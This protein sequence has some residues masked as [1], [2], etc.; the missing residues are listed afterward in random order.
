MGSYVVTDRGAVTPYLFTGNGGQ[1]MKYFRFK[2]RLYAPQQRWYNSEQPVVVA[3]RA[4]ACSYDFLLVDRPFDSRRLTVSG[5]T[6]AENGSAA[7]MAIDARRFRCDRPRN[8]PPPPS[9]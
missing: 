8:H 4:I 1:P 5:P 6:V 3:G 2:E 7:L 9:H